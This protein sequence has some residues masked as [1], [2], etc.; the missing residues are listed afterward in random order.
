[1]SEDRVPS[2]EINRKIIHL[3]S[4]V[5]PALYA[6]LGDQ[7]LMIQITGTVLVVL[8]LSEILRQRFT[9]FSTL[10]TRLFGFSMRTHEAH[11]P[12]GATYFLIGT[13]LCIVMFDA[14]IAIVA[15]VILVVSDTCASL[16][17]LCFGRIRLING[18]SLEGT[19]AFA[20]SALLIA[21]LGATLSGLYFLPMLVAALATSIFELFNKQF[22]LNDN[23]LIPLG[24]ASTATILM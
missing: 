6:M 7:T 13:F 9:R 15:L 20:T 22:G 19:L 14:P 23:I 2:T 3:T 16:V 4:L 5:Y 8:I 24:F 17:G 11:R 21:Y 18:K 12:T 1:M 10:Y